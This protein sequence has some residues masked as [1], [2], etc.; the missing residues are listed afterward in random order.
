MAQLD[1][2]IQVAGVQ[3][4]AEARTCLNAGADLIGIPLRLPVNAE[5]LSEAEAAS[6]SRQLPGKCC[7]I[8]YLDEPDEIAAFVRE[9]EVSFLQLHGDID[10][11]ILP[12][13][14]QALPGVILI[15][16]LIV[17]R[18]PVARLEQVIAQ[19]A[20]AVH[21]FITD[22]FNPETGAEGAT[23]LLHDWSVSRHLIQTS[24]CPVILA[25]GLNAG[26]VAAAIRATGARAVDSHTGVED[27]SGRKTASLVGAFVR[28]AREAL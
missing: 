25:G 15:K 24:P 28:A 22:S 3:D 14:R 18:D 5:D 1:G 16:S 19:C 4:L 11:A 6:I 13:V 2:L 23:G 20:P 26:N 17:G 9:L 7:L 8:T 12:H 10:P 27:A 21:A